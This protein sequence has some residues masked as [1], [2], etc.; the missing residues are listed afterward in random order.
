MFRLLCVWTT[1]SFRMAKLIRVHNPS[2]KRALPFLIT[3]KHHETI[4]GHRHSDRILIMKTVGVFPACQWLRKRPL[5]VPSIEE[6][7]HFGSHYDYVEEM[8]LCF[9]LELWFQIAKGSAHIL[10]QV[11]QPCRF[12]LGMAYSWLSQQ[13]PT[14][15]M[16]LHSLSAE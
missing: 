4:L 9:N 15:L 5:W 7:N 12:A 11:L 1:M 2:Y 16:I 8:F 6:E 3:A 10:E 14:L 13:K